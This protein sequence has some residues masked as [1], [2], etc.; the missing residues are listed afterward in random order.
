M[1]ESGA[2]SRK[3][4]PL[5][6]SLQRDLTLYALAAG[7]AGVSV[8]ALAQ[9]SEAEVMY[10]AVHHTI[11]Q[12]QEYAL[13]LNHDGLTDFTIQNLFREGTYQ[14]RPYSFTFQ[15]QALPAAGN[16][17]Q[18][19]YQSYLAAALPPGFQ[20][21]PSKHVKFRPEIMA[22]QFRIF[23]TYYYFGSWLNVSNRYLGIQLKINGDL[24]FG[25]VR[26]TV[27]SNLKRR[28]MATV[29]GYAY[30][31]VPNQP[32]IAGDTGGISGGTEPTPKSALQPEEGTATLGAL[33]LG[34]G[35]LAI[36]RRS[37]SSVSKAPE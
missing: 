6:H 18:I 11:S 23:G 10:T 20:I 30:E 5:S 8:L 9:S 3:L 14:G 33:S 13:D 34:A 31:T 2:Q 26:L 7:A 17:V 1:S 21:G 36:W 29:T 27:Q 25:W 22:E 16:G 12:G 15:V 28:L 35:G 37:E 4:V 19:G 24:H 32:I